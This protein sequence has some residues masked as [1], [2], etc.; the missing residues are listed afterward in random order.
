[1]KPC[2]ELTKDDFNTSFA[3]LCVLV[4]LTGLY[5][6]RHSCVVEQVWH[7]SSNLNEFGGS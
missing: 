5:F 6:T 3:P 4:S 1:M 2:F 7:P